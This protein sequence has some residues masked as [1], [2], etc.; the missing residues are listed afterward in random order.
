MRP[1]HDGIAV[2]RCSRIGQN[3]APETGWCGMATGWGE[4][5]SLSIN[6]RPE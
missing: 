1:T 5:R 3:V 4:I 6:G 2:V